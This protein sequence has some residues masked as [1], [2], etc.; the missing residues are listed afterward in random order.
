[1]Q[2]PII[3]RNCRLVSRIAPA[4]CGTDSAMSGCALQPSV[5]RDAAG[6]VSSR[7]SLRRVGV[8]VE[9]NAVSSLFSP[10]AF[11]R[12][13]YPRTDVAQYSW[14][15]AQPQ[16][17]ASGPEVS[18]RAGSLRLRQGTAGFHG[19]LRAGCAWFLF[20]PRSVGFGPTA[21][22][23]NGAFTIVPSILCQAHAIPSNSSYSAKPRR[24]IFTNT[25]TRF[26]SRKYWCTELALPYSFGNAFHW[27]PVRRMYTIPANMRRGSKGFRPPPGRLLYLRPVARLCFG[28]SGVT[29][30]HRA[31]ETVHDL[32]VL[33]YHSIATPGL[34]SN[35]YLRISS[36]SNI[37]ERDKGDERIRLDD[38]ISKCYVKN[39]LMFV[40]DLEKQPSEKR[41]SSVVLSL[42]SL[43]SMFEEGSLC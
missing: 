30:S 38:P 7:V 10:Q 8:R 19:R 11:L 12:S 15:G 28:I 37:D 1:M 35:I 14:G 43:S 33:M 16:M 36:K 13:P 22:K 42:L 21:S 6:C 34:G 29:R 27:Q 4:A 41:A 18:Y 32:S 2:S 20:F 17:S 23:A 39:A 3:L 24:H 5:L 40:I 31:S 25:P 26:H 9:C